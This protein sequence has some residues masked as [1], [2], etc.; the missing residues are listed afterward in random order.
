[1]RK[2]R[3]VITL[4]F[5][6]L[7][8]AVSCKKKDGDVNANTEV[9]DHS[10][11]SIPIDN[12]KFDGFFASHP[13]FKAFEGDV[14]EL[15]KKHNHYIWHD[16]SGLIEFAEVLH[17]RVNQISK[18]GLTSKIPY[19]EQ[20]NEVFENSDGKPEMESELLISSMYFYYTKKVLEGMDPNKSK[21]TGWYLPREKVDYVAYLDTLM[22]DPKLIKED[23]SELFSQYYNLRKGLQ[24]YRAI[25]KKG[26]WGTIALNE[27]VKSLK[28]GDSAAAIVQIRKRL[29]L[30]GYLKSDSKKAVFDADLAAGM[31]AYEEK[32]NREFDGKIGPLT[33]KELNVPVADLIRTISV[34]MERCR[35]ISPDINTSKE[36]IAVNIPSYRLIY[37][38]DGKPFLTSNVVVGKELNKTVVFSGEMSY[39]QFAPYWNVPNSILEK[40]I[41][42][43]IA[44]NP[45]Y[46]AQN[47]M[48][49]HEGRVRQKPGDKNSLGKVKFMFPNT[50]NIY[51]HDTPAKSLFNKDDRAFS[52]GCVR[53][54]KA[55]DLAIAITKKDGNWNESKVD[56]AMNA[57]KE[58]TYTLK[59]KIP[60]YIAYFT[61]WA[62]ENGNVAFY[63][64]VYERDGRLAS[65]LYAS[66]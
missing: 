12:T 56:A 64:D 17:N 48:E 21:Q 6:C 7:F 5:G 24:K 14:K 60:V 25:E 18:E 8:V 20:L 62:D 50:N 1:M 16:K 3:L 35:W 58:S 13:E 34:N 43:D 28:E 11:A 31:K 22:E 47:D 49:W 30:E 27:G 19:K 40:E 66:K 52:H 54:E 38:R 29:A 57:G 45:N 4:V 9:H 41:K 55:R 44:K 51:L 37:T 36:Y 10:D 42:P 59:T 23:K 46:L 39:L 65:L 32:H 15:Y 26:G 2:A 63:D 33:V 61:A 53:V